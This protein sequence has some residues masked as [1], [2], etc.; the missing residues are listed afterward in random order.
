MKLQIKSLAGSLLFESESESLKELL[1]GAVE[2][3]ANLSGANLYGANLSGADLY[4]ANLSG[5]NLYGA[6]LSG[7]NL[8]GAN[9]YGADLSGANLSGANLSGANLSGADLSGANLYGADLSGA[10]LSGANLSGANLYRANLSGA[11]LYGADLSRANLSG[12]NLYGAD[13]SRANLSGAEGIKDLASLEWF[14][15]NFKKTK[16]GVIVYKCFHG[17]FAPNPC[18]KIEPGTVLTEICGPMP[19][20]DCA[21]GLNF[22][23]L[24]WVRANHPGKIIWR[25]LIRWAW[26]PGVVIPW[27][28]NGKARCSKLMLLRPLKEGETK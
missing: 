6:N 18:W 17:T 16:H 28:T 3:R 10:N 22:A 20:D 8:S 24:E 5:A 26:L 4:R 12:A 14:M 2:S 9:L 1:V 27:N 15:R 23:T 25:C 7:A 11:N 13:L 21:C 19:T